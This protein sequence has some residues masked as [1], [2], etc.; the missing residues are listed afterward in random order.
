MKKRILSA[1]LAMAM[2]LS[3]A[4]CESNS[5][6][7]DIDFDE[8]GEKIENMSDDELENAVIDGVEKLE[9]LGEADTTTT[10]Q[11]EAV[12]EEESYEPLQEIIDAD[13]SD[14]LVQ[15]GDDIFRMGGYM[16]VNDFVEQYGDKYDMTEINLNG[17]VKPNDGAASS[18][19]KKDSSIKFL[20]SYYNK[21]G[22]R[23]KIGDAVIYSFT[24]SELKS[25]FTPQNMWYA[26]G[27]SYGNG[28]LYDDFM[29]ILESKGITEDK[30]KWKE[31]NTYFDE[32]EIKVELS[33]ENLDGVKAPIVEYYTYFNDD[34][35][36]FN[37]LN[38]NPYYNY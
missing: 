25:E 9:N 7:E 16:T 28:I 34:E 31:S 5:G 18:I 17:F 19:Q 14:G 38:A 2:V 13:F 15:I 37:G 35:G 27:I 36:T 20:I 24:S 32:I 26:G 1:L 12:P 30:Y 22:E 10:A 23:I 21:T 33:E 6:T 8:I 4:G 29:K 11:T 3:V